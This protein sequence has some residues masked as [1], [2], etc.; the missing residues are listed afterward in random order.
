M[1][2]TL[3][4]VLNDYHA[5]LEANHWGVFEADSLLG[6]FSRYTNGNEFTAKWVA[7]IAA[8]FRAAGGGAALVRLPDSA[9]KAS[10]KAA[11]LDHGRHHVTFDKP[12]AYGSPPATGYT[13]DPV[14]T[15]TGN[16]VEV[17]GDLLC[18]G[19]VAGLTFERTYNSRSDRLGPFGRGWSSWASARLVPGPEGAAYIGPDGQEAVFPRL[20]DGYGRVVGVAALVEPLESGLALRWLGGAARWV[21]D[22]AGRPAA[23]SNGPGTEIRLEND[24]DGRLVGMSHAGGKHVRLEWDEDAERIVALACSDGRSAA[25]RY[26]ASGDLVEA[27]GAAGARR[28]EVDE[29]GRV[30]SVIDADGVVELV[31]TYD[32]EG[33][34]VEQLSPFGRRTRLFYL[35]GGVT[36]TMDDDEDHPANTFVHDA[37][38]RLTAVIDGDE[39][40]LSTSYD[41]WGNPTAVTE[42]NGVVTIQEYDERGL[43]LRRVLPTGVVLTFAH[44]DADRLVEVAVGDAVTR[45]VFD[46]D[47]RSPSQITDPEGGVTRQDVQDGLVRRIVDPDGVTVE[48]EHDA[49][50]NV[51]GTTDGDGNHTRLER[52][53]AGRVTALV[54]PLGRRTAFFYDRNGLLVE[55]QDPD[56]AAWRYDHTAAGRLT[57]VTDPTGA[58]EQIRYAEHGKTAATVDALGHVATRDYDVFGN[59]VGVVEPDGT[60]WRYTY[61][62]LMRW[63]GTV[64]PAGAIWRRQY[65]VNGTLIASIDPVGTRTTASVDAYGRVVGLDD[66]LVVTTYELDEL[67]R[68]V[69]CGLSDGTHAR[70]E[71]DRCGRRTLVEDAAG[72]VLR[73]E[74]T[75][76][77]RI[78]RQVSPEGREESL[79]H[80]A[81]GRTSAHVDG[82]GRR[83]E[84]RYDADGAVIEVLMATGESERFKYDELGRLSQT[85]APGAGLTRYAY[86]AVGRVVASL[87]REAGERR[88]EYDAAGRLVAATDAN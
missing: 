70:T 30:V 6:A 72:G 16:F 33:R 41:E 87:D 71:Y 4:R 83:T 51:T 67:G 24:S 56:G 23:V 65:D 29:T 61:D 64:D 27:E 44:D 22:E 50:G 63:T 8:R 13:D 25:Y 53:D 62:A 39:Q 57:S 74:Y 86:E 34:V 45:Y 37:E 58:R 19:L 3:R 43:P 42:R 2:T 36:V 73:I 75:A 5:F 77:G 85:S 12:V 15:A 88:F 11:G 79:E 35:P 20:G 40:Q 76:G 28:Y 59:L 60:S 80:D 49:D 48:F 26:D 66:G 32:E 9:I 10:L 21:F 38:G 46:G 55:R 81:C 17:E 84:L 31:N 69:G 52:D 7:N 68:L 14:N 18:G 1:V 47:E 82:A 54:S 78:R